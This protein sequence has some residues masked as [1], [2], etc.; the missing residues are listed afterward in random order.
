M[1]TR[2]RNRW[3]PK[4]YPIEKRRVDGS[5]SRDLLRLT[6]HDSRQDGSLPPVVTCRSVRRPEL[7]IAIHSSLLGSDSMGRLL[8]IK[9]HT[10]HLEHCAVSRT[11]KCR[12]D[13][14]NILFYLCRPKGV[15]PMMRELCDY[16]HMSLAKYFVVE[17]NVIATDA[18]HHCNEKGCTDLIFQTF[19][20]V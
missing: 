17:M 2:L 15:R 5:T 8:F 6:S 12:V 13:D 3:R 19:N 14:Y 11:T 16:S 7:S 20:S 10:R 18:A 1:S 9:K 4:K